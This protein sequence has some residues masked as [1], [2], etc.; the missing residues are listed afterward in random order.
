MSPRT[1]N[2]ELKVGIFVIIG[3]II[4]TVIVFEIG[5]F[6]IFK[7]GYRIH[8]IFNYVSGIDV[9]APINLSGVEVGEIKNMEIFYNEN[10][11]K[12]QV[13]ITAW[14]QKDIVIRE[15]SIAKIKTLGI[16]GEKYLELTPGSIDN[17]PLKDGGVLFGQ[18]PVSI[19]D[20][21]E[22]IN[23]VAKDLDKTIYSVNAIVGEVGVQQSLT[24]SIENFREITKRANSI[25]VKIDEGQGTVGK[26]IN[27]DKIYRDL[28]GLVADLKKHPWKLLR[29]TREKKEKSKD[30]EKET[31]RKKS[32]KE[33]SVFF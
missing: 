23:R 33:E 9:G 27:E 14:I 5:D 12:T 30:K 22:T 20:V 18:D 10:L 2:F 8:I 17:K 3:L 24:E 11:A 25:L 28:E 6:K 7:P 29:K 1:P 26:L 13:D 32:L 16:L 21:A 31:D 4:L 19:E 15:N